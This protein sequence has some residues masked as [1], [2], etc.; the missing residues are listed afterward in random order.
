[1]RLRSSLLLIASF[2][3]AP[4]FAGESPRFS[5]SISAE[6]RTAAGLDVL[7]SDQI[8]ALDA[9]VRLNHRQVGAAERK[10]AT[11]RS[12]VAAA[13]AADTTSDSFC[14]SLSPDQLRAA[15][16]DRLTAAQQTDLDTIVAALYAP[17]EVATA[18]N[19]KTVQA[20]EFFPDRWEV[21]GEFGLSFGFG[22]HDYRSRAAWLHTTLL[23][24]KTGT[25][26]SV[27]VA[28]GKEEGGRGW[29]PYGR[30]WDRHGRYGDY[31]WDSI[32]FG[33]KLPPFG[34]R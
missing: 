30:G 12:P 3:S 15:G 24:T 1:M 32:S 17:A 6:Q 27:G 14:A 23:D 8:A 21:H 34:G 7:D 4:L 31:E 33:L 19:T 10:P 29:Y 25:E 5:M 2:L 13:T 20:V 22:S 16:L 28:T 9:L 18:T 11:E 26:F